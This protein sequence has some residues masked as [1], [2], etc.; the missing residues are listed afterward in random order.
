VAA[1]D[2]LRPVAWHADADA[3][4]I[5]LFEVVARAGALRDWWN[6]PGRGKAVSGIDGMWFVRN[7][8]LHFGAD[9][10]SQVTVFVSG[11]GQGPFGQGPFGGSYTTPSWMWKPSHQFPRARSNIGRAEYDSMLAGKSVA[12]TTETIR[13]ALLRR[14]R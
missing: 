1:H 7:R 13:Q 9:A 8:V 5:A 11:F 4:F 12:M 10:L 14:R 6:V 3:A 2:R